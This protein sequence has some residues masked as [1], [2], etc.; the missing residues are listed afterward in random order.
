MSTDDY[1][2]SRSTP[3]RIAISSE[4]GGWS[5]STVMYMYRYSA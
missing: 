5:A 1:V 3:Q 4:H 2:D